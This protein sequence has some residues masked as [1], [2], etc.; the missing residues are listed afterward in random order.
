M[1]ESTLS[2]LIGALRLPESSR[3][4]QRVPKKLLVENG[5]PTS[6]D[7]RLINDGVDEIQWVAAIKPGTSGI[8]EYRDEAREY[9]EVAVLV[10]R[11]RQ[12]A[13]TGSKATRLAELVHRAVPYPVLLLADHNAAIHVSL[14]HKRWSQNEAGKV[15]LDDGGIVTEIT[16]ELN[17]D[18]LQ[19]FLEALA[20]DQQPKTSLLT[21]Y[22]GWMD[23]LQ[24]LNA[25]K[26][27]GKFSQPGTPDQAATQRQA[28]QEMEKL[29]AEVARLRT[30]ASKEKQLARQ[31]EMNLELKRLQ[32]KITEIRSSL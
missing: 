27:T 9:L 23:T 4:N 3:V 6:L 32:S 22:Q 13:M 25:A 20:L 10:I 2:R 11:L 21:V 17:P 19:Q 12:D 5:A 1:T 24:A 15:V 30:A 16:A 29:N 31:V 14:A 28:L 18:I 8:A 7:K 26:L